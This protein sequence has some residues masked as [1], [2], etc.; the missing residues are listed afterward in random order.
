DTDCT[1]QPNPYRTWSDIDPSLP[2][3]RIEVY[4]PPPTSG[5]RDAFVELG[6]E[7]GAKAY[8]C[9]AELASA[10]SAA[11][12]AAAHTLREDGAW[13]DAGENDNAIV[14]TLVRTPSAFGVFGYSFLDQNSDRLHAA[15]IDGVAPTY[16]AISSGEYPVSRTMFIY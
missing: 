5:T 6:M 3:A 4:G 12:T 14:Q 1:L 10:D 7:R 2:S 13:I 11:F 9:L 8:P 16:E 15:A